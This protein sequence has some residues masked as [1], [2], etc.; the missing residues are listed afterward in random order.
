MTD[1]EPTPG[2]LSDEEIRTV[3]SGAEGNGDE[4]CRGCRRCDTT[5]ADGVDT[6]DAQDADGV[7]TTDADGVDTTDADGVDTT[8]ADGVDTTDA[9][10]G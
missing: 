10:G 3:G 9:P 7:T 4:E 8:D 5:D 2:T 6:T 1:K